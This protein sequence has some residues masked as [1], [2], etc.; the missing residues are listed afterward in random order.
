MILIILITTLLNDSLPKKQTL[1]YFPEY[2]HYIIIVDSDSLI[3]KKSI[4]GYQYLSIKL[5]DSCKY[6]EVKCYRSKDSTLK[7]SGL[8][9]NNNFK[10][11]SNFKTY[12]AGSNKEYKSTK[13]VVRFKRIGP[14]KYYNK[15]GSLIKTVNF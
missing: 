2:K 1:G 3:S 12:G 15:N 11:A 8:Y 14:W 6:A 9:Y 13:D 10:M 7:E 4:W 5:Y